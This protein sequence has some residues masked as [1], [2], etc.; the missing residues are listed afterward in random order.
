MGAG[1]GQVT[2]GG[3]PPLPGVALTM[4]CAA[5]R[6]LGG[7]SAAEILSVRSLPR[8]LKLRP[9]FFPWVRGWPVTELVISRIKREKGESAMERGESVFGIRR[10]AS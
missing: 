1:E 6:E 7:L 5:L 2:V 3:A 9:W 8:P 4:A 10:V